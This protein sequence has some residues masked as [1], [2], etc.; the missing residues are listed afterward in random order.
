MV[1]H[2]WRTEYYWKQSLVASMLQNAW[3]RSSS[4]AL[5]LRCGVAACPPAAANSCEAGMR[6]LWFASCC[7]HTDVE[8]LHYSCLHLRCTCSLTV[9]WPSARLQLLRPSAKQT[10]AF[11]HAVCAPCVSGMSRHAAKAGIGSRCPPRPRVRRLD[12]R[13]HVQL[14]RYA[15]YRD[16]ST[17]LRLLHSLPAADIAC[18]PPSCTG[19]QGL[20]FKHRSSGGTHIATGRH[21]GTAFRLV[22]ALRLHNELLCDESLCEMASVCN[23]KGAP[24]ALP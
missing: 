13:W 20:G 1:C 7:T 12:R 4:T 6:R 18:A 19:P 21:A 8:L 9:L 10:S 16:F 15:L 24:P 23:D 14:R 11:V 17:A 22:D 3:L 2:Y 5:P